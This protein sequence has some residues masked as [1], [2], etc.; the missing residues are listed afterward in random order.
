MFL[1]LKFIFDQT[2][3]AGASIGRFFGIH[4]DE[5]QWNRAGTLPPN[6][7]AQRYNLVS[8]QDDSSVAVVATPSN[9]PLPQDFLSQRRR[10]RRCGFSHITDNIRRRFSQRDPTREEVMKT[11]PTFWPI[12][13]IL[14]A[15]VEIGML[16]ATIATGGLAPIRLTPVINV[17]TIVGFDNI[18]DSASK[19][20]VP[21]FFIGTS[22]AALIHTG[23]MYTPVS[24]NTSNIVRI[25]PL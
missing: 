11:L 13:T 23:A 15:V 2:S 3:N 14:I 21:N 10:K 12:M 18:Q 8:Q 22:K 6:S 20:I 4:D 5:I 7:R 17:S 16:I 24:Y 9:R 19:E 1:I 25:T